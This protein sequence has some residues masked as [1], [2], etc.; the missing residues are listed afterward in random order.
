M[1]HYSTWHIRAKL[2]RN[3]MFDHFEAK[4]WRTLVWDLFIAT[5]PPSLLPRMPFGCLFKI[6][7]LIGLVLSNEIISSLFRAVWGKSAQ[8]EAKWSAIGVK[9][10][11]CFSRQYQQLRFKW[12]PISFWLLRFCKG[13]VSILLFCLKKWDLHRNGA[14]LLVGS[15]IRR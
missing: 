11:P 10:I 8:T 1:L 5:K 9:N 2:H 12:Y 13:L 4:N 6:A 14:R 3:F 7:V 15:I